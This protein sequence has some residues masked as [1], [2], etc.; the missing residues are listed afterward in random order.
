MGM[1]FL[2]MKEVWSRNIVERLEYDL[3]AGLRFVTYRRHDI[4]IQE[5]VGAD[6]EVGFQASIGFRGG[7]AKKVYALYGDPRFLMMQL[8]RDRYL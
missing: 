5:L 1:F 8:K 3:Q 4:R 7:G 6:Y 2:L